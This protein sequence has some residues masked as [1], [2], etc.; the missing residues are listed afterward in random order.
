M[1][2]ALIFDLDDTLIDTSG[3]SIPIKM[4]EAL[5]TMIEAGLK[6]N[7]VEQAYQLLMKIDQS[8]PNGTESI[9]NFLKEFNADPKFLPIGKAAYYGGQEL[10][11]SI[12]EL[13]GAS[14]LLKQLKKKYQLVLVS[15]GI[16]SEQESKLKKSGLTENLFSL[17]IFTDNYNKK[18]EYIK[19]INQLKIP[20][21]QFI[22]VG[23]KVKSDLLP[24][25]ELRMKT[26]HMFWGR[27]KLDNPKEADYSIKKLSELNEI[28]TKL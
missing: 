16:K 9:N 5:K 21:E 23:D 17:I 19:V 13:E 27:G 24:A 7:D 20:A 18:E 2:K 25:K 8:S 6:I 14:K 10:D 22:V 11:F 3:C 28:L 15:Y 4:K 1:I 12:K 26:V